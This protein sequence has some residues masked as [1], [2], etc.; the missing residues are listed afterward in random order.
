MVILDTQCK[1]VDRNENDPLFVALKTI[2]Q[3]KLKSYLI[4]VNQFSLTAL[5]LKK[6]NIMRCEIIVDSQSERKIQKVKLQKVSVN[7]HIYMTIKTWT[8]AE[9]TATFYR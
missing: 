3:I 4:L 9:R 8:K 5:V 2:Q 6:G 1:T 7:L